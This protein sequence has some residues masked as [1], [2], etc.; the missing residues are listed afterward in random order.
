MAIFKLYSNHGK[1]QCFPTCHPLDEHITSKHDVTVFS[2]A[3]ATAGAIFFFV[4]VVVQSN[5]LLYCIKCFLK[6]EFGVFMTE[7]SVSR[8]SRNFYGEWMDPG[9]NYHLAYDI[10]FNIPCQICPS[11]LH[12][13]L[14]L[15]L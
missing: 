4:A 13:T 11:N 5:C 1:L 14:P 10:S 7:A 9:E 12:V 15:F 3:T 2:A 6:Y 8:D